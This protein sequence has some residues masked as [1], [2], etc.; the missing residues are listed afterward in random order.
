MVT[1]NDDICTGPCDCSQDLHE[2]RLVVVTGG[3]GAGKTAVL[4]LVRRSLC[5]HVVI[6]PEAA[7]IV[8]GGGFPRR[9]SR[10]ARRASQRVIFHVQREMERLHVEEQQAA[11][12]LCDRG[13]LG[14]IAYWPGA[15]DEFLADVGTDSVTE[16]AR[17]EAVIHLRTPTASRGY[18]LSNPLRVEDAEQAAEIDD[19][20]EQAWRPHP[21]RTIIDSADDFSAKA[22]RALAAIGLELPECCDLAG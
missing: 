16:I 4:E 17:Y 10:S 9:S 7:G 20:I 22:S 18:D 12:V 21:R 6:L 14:G 13:T 15:P 11:I 19:R 2:P 3:P 1:R 8:F 5:R